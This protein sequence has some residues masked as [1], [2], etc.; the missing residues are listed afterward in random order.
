[1]AGEGVLGLR[2]AFQSAGVRTVINSL[3]PVE[4]EETRLWMT[5][6]YSSHFAR[7]RDTA[8]A[9]RDAQITRLRARQAKGLSTHPFYWAGFVA[10][11]DWR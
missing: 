7:G 11:G 6:L 8:D 5:A 2:R 10:V 1:M 3:W 9:V 4:D